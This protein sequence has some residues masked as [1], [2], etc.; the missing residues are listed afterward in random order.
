MGTLQLFIKSCT[1][2]DPPKGNMKN[3]KGSLLCN[4]ILAEMKKTVEPASNDLFHYTLTP[5]TK[6][7]VINEHHPTRAGP[8]GVFPVQATLLSLFPFC[9]LV[10]STRFG[11]VVIIREGEASYFFSLSN[12]TPFPVL[13]LMCKNK[14]R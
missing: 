4:F 5:T 8:V 12:A 11:V 2:A 14:R 13:S 1:R 3:Q 6:G 7:L 10:S 9:L